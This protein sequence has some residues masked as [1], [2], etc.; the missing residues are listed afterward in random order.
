MRGCS[1]I[2]GTPGYA[3]GQLHHCASLL[4]PVC[5]DIAWFTY[6]T[7]FARRAT[8]P[9]TNKGRTR[10]HVP[11]QAE[12]LAL[13][14]R[15]EENQR[16]SPLAD[17][18]RANF[19]CALF[20]LHRG[21]RR[22]CY[23]RQYLHRSC[24]PGF[25]AQAHHSDSQAWLVAE[26]SLVT[27][28]D[29]SVLDEKQAQREAAQQSRDENAHALV[30]DGFLVP[31]LDSP[32]DEAQPPAYGEQHDHV[33]FSQPGFDAGAEVTGARRF[34]PAHSQKEPPPLPLFHCRLLLR[35]MKSN[36]SAVSG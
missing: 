1:R 11:S 35:S 13:V 27:C 5:A 20:R 19:R 17:A 9:T 23:P 29:M 3:D 6:G 8:R 7:C 28:A 15:A 21:A 31:S 10:F 34:L 36:D 32:A 18:A 24:Q 22:G 33:R 12:Q 26:R 14:S 4:S 25:H 16:S 30:T 2:T